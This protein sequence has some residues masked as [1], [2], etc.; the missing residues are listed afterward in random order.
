MINTLPS[1][2]DDIVELLHLCLCKISFKECTIYDLS[3]HLHAPVYVRYLSISVT[4]TSIA[5]TSI[6]VITDHTNTKQRICLYQSCTWP[7]VKKKKFNFRVD[8]PRRK[9]V[10]AVDT[11]ADTLK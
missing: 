9:E 4:T 2:F 6:Q 11:S 10:F 1:S 3:T 5:T 7:T 8:E